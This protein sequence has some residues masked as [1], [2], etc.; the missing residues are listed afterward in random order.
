MNEK[1]KNI[2]NKKKNITKL[3]PQRVSIVF[4]DKQD[5]QETDF[6]EEDQ[7]TRGGD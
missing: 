4:C 6:S 1:K 5:A 2:L 3:A 7:K